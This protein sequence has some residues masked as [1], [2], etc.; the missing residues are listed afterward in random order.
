MTSSNVYGIF[1]REFLYLNI[2]F[3]SIIL[4][5]G[6]VSGFHQNGLKEVKYEKYKSISILYPINYQ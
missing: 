4:L 6:F 3:I 5:P 2:G 1:Y